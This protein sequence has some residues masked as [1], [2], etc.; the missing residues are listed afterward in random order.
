MGRT[1]HRRGT[2]QRNMFCARRDLRNEADVEQNFV[3]RLIESL[4]Y[5]DR[6]I[7]P[8]AALEALA[9]GPL[10][11][12]EKYRPDFAIKAAGISG[13]YWKRRPRASR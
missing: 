1:P 7:R 4:G 5:T 6:A 12:A 13:G 11:G 9:V 2:A 8:Q 3:R 10:A